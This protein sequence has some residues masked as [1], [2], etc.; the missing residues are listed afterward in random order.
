VALNLG[1]VPVIDGVKRLLILA[2]NDAS[3]TGERFARQLRRAWQARGRE[4]IARMPR[5]V[6]S[7]FNDILRS[8][9]HERQRD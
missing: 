9:L 7:D 3:K 8:E 4:V 1:R 5:T 6:G 2:D